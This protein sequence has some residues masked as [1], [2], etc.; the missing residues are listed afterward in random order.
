MESLNHDMNDMDALFRKAAKGYPLKAGDGGWENISGKLL[1]K[2]EAISPVK[3][4]KRRKYFGLIIL[5]FLI[6]GGSMFYLKVQ[7]YDLV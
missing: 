5:F 2:P 1:T 4:N 7:K 3:I 6:S